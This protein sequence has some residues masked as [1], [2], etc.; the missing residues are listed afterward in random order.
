M[1]R[2]S[3]GTTLLL[4]GPALTLVRAAQPAPALLPPDRPIEQ[5]VDHYLDAALQQAKVRPAPQADD[6]ALLRRLTLDLAGR[7]P[8]VSETAEYLA[9]GDPAKK[10]KLVER[11]LAAPG[12]VRH[13]A[14][15]FFTLLSLEEKGRRA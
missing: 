11:L 13:Q 4:I 1:L 15:E 2:Y 10:A 5:V 7:I 14:Q 6:A 8:T 12:F 3:L 9:A